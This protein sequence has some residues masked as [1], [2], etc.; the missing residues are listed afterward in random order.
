MD[1]TLE[2]RRP[3]ALEPANGLGCISM[4]GK[5]C[6]ITLRYELLE[7]LIR[8]DDEKDCILGEIQ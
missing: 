7:Y 5:T 2:D 4:E 6:L 1:Q 8:L 3:D